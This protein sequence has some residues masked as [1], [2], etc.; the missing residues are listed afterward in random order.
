MNQPAVVELVCC[1]SRQVLPTWQEALAPRLEAV[2]HHVVAAHERDHAL[3]D[4][5]HAIADVGAQ[6]E[7]VPVVCQSS[8]CALGAEQLIDGRGDQAEQSLAQCTNIRV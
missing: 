6:A 8:T 4:E 7:D 2:Q 3:V 1:A 5:V